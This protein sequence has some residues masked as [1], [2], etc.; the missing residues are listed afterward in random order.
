MHGSAGNPNR[1][2][3][4]WQVVG[5]CSLGLVG[6]STF[7]Q[8]AHWLKRSSPI[9]FDATAWSTDARA[10][11]SEPLRYRMAKHLASSGE[12]IGKRETDVRAMLDDPPKMVREVG[13]GA[14][15][16]GVKQLGGSDSLF[17]QVEFDEHHDVVRV[18]G[19]P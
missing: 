17:L 2:S 14:R 5:V 19:P 4:W 12:L 16:Y 13:G 8:P 6:M 3:R 9:P 11:F 1:P 7:V 18:V 15:W 10:W